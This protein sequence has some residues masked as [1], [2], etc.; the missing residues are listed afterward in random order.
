M[1]GLM[2]IP[3][4]IAII[5]LVEDVFDDSS[6]YFKKLKNNKFKRFKW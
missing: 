2:V 1:I 5:I 3:N 4:V 6:N